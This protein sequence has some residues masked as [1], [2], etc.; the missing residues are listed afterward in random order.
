[1]HI[2]SG[3]SWAV[4]LGICVALSAWAGSSVEAQ[5]YKGNVS[6]THA[7][8]AANHQLQTGR[9]E[10]AEAKYT[11]IL[12]R[13]PHNAAARAALSLA[14]A[15]LYKLDA[16][17]KNANEVLF[18]Y[19]KNAMAHM[20]KGV[21]DRNRT[22]S[23]DMTWR[24]QQDTLLE[25]SLASL[26]QSVKLNPRSAEAFNQLGITYRHMG[27]LDE[28]AAA[29]KKSL[30]LDPRY[31]EA[32][33]N[34]GVIELARGKTESAINEYKQAIRL[35]SKNPMAHYR[36]GEALL[37]Q[38]D[39][40]GAIKSLNTAQSLDSDNAIIHS[41]LADAYETQGNTAAA[42]ASYRKALA[43][44]PTY[45]PA[46]KAIANIFDKRG[47]GELAMAELR[48]ALN[49]SPK[50]NEGRI[51][52]GKLALSVD[53]P[54]QAVSHFKEALSQDSGNTEAVQ[55]LA[56]A[57]SAVAS[58]QANWS[59]T[60]GADSDLLQAEQ[61]VAD[62]LRLT[63][64]DMGLHLA[65]LRISR[66]AGKPAAGEADLDRLIKRQPKNESE[67][68]MQ[69][70]AL[71]TLGR[72]Q[73]ADQVF[74]RL[75]QRANNNPEKLLVLGDTLKSNGDLLRARDAYSLALRAEP[76][77]LKAKRGLDR[78]TEAQA[79]AEKTVRL[80]HALN[81]WRGK[82]SSIDYYEEALSQNPRQPEA[83]LALAKLYERT[84]QYSKAYRSFE[85]YL[86]LRP[87]LT[88]REREGYGRRMNRL[89]RLAAKY[90]GVNIQIAMPV[91]PIEQP[92]SAG[93]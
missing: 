71:L 49:A 11:A 36:L 87:D 40:H 55:G 8:H 85:Y 81:T 35:N 84:K 20:A 10:A 58:K 6:Y 3:R 4:A 9:Y 13:N 32:R 88:E 17:E 75:L 70:E 22:A 80:A 63:P 86:S 73:E 2:T 52:L 78:V 18:K 54:A 59:Q 19:P 76:G 60:V 33:L 56:Q 26:Q 29:F 92:L 69:G 42:V 45:M 74:A 53:K 46:Y 57:L 47:D 1:M 31:A 25:K 79:E 64:N 28:A 50:W 5:S 77:N 68:M 7:F 43:S 41:K 91:T 62:A 61:A 39:A 15:E 30:S 44:N 21:I 66:L 38:G 24:N 27:K 83:R 93:Q 14:Q 51:L 48:S 23:M 12:K 67:E 82:G 34:N 65:H 89:Q 16:A 72:Y 37:M 90:E